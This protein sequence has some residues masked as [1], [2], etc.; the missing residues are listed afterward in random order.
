VEW[1]VTAD[2]MQALSEHAAS[3]QWLMRRTA[4]NQN[5]RAIY[6]SA[7]GAAALGN[8]DLAPTITLEF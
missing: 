4:E 2:V 8:P 5:G 3:I 1:D 7:D 6:H